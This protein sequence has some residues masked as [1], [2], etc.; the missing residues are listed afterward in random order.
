MNY[1]LLFFSV[2]F[3]A[4]TM[5]FAQISTP[6][7]GVNW[8]MDDLID[9]FPNL[10]NDYEEGGERICE[11]SSE[12][13]IAATDTLT[14]SELHLKLGETSRISSELAHVVFESLTLSGLTNDTFPK[15]RF[16][17]T[18]VLINNVI[19]DKGGGLNFVDSDFTIND[20]KFYKTL[21]LEAGVS[22]AISVFRSKG[23]ISNTLFEETE[24]AALSSGVNAAISLVIDHCDFIGNN[25]K[26]K[27]SPQLNFADTAEGDSI[28]VKNSVFLGG[29]DMSGGIG[30]TNLIQRHATLI[31]ENNL[32]QG[33]RYGVTVIG[34]NVTS[35]IRNNHIIGNNI[36]GEPNLGGSGINL[37][38]TESNV[39]Y[40]AGNHI[41]DN[42]WG[43]TIQASNAAEFIAPIAYLSEPDGE[44]LPYPTTRNAFVNNGNSGQIYALFNM[45]DE[46]I[47]ARENYWNT[48]DS[49]EVEDAIFHKNDDPSLGLVIYDNFLLV[50]PDS[51]SVSTTN[52]AYQ[53]YETL[54]IYPNPLQ[55]GNDVFLA[56]DM[57]AGSL[58]V[59]NSTGSIIYTR[60]FK[61]SPQRIDN[62][63]FGTGQY[64]LM[65]IADS[66]LK[67][68]S[69]LIIFD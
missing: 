11:I 69:K 22:P 40:L 42:L 15:M 38:G 47:Y 13:I 65:Y 10:I 62:L 31:V 60:H 33:N 36:Q 3:M 29:N 37:Y 24:S 20:S 64:Y 45:N 43:L 53:A 18:T 30:L 68:R 4:G 26:N 19:F 9:A 2:L 51:I 52:P 59:F 58:K 14:I 6:G 1:R 32:I 67:Y 12:L 66:G 25:T 41:E 5:S 7:T 21:S 8:N 55:S 48:A 63:S 39:S 27:N 50:H 49:A 23:L 17:S 54:N 16:D 35:S 56:T 46:T 61:E 34:S 57:G 44:T 28:V